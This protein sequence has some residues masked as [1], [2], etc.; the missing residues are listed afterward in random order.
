MHEKKF[1]ESLKEHV[2][3]IINFEKKKMILLSKS[4]N[5]MVVTKSAMQLTFEDKYADDKKI[6]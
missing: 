5:H 3:K 4:T 2:I 6:L 1:C